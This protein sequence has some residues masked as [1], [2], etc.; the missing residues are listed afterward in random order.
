MFYIRAR[1]KNPVMPKMLQKEMD[2]RRWFPLWW[3]LALHTIWRYCHSQKR[4][5]FRYQKHVPLQLY[6]V[7]WSLNNKRISI[8]K[9]VLLFDFWLDSTNDVPKT[10]VKKDQV[11]NG[12]TTSLPDNIFHAS[13]KDRNLMSTKKKIH[14]E[15]QDRLP[16]IPVSSCS[17]SQSEI[18]ILKT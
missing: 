13:T 1:D 9:I 14:E 7:L 3:S 8:Y 10:T 6:K 12:Q 15:Y 4:R 18:K 16:V 5:S 2:M 11:I 17:T